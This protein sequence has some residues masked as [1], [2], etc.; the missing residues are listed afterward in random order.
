M[1]SLLDQGQI[2]HD[3]HDPV[4]HALQ[5]KSLGGAFI[6]D[7]FDETDITYV[8]SGNGVGEIQ[9]VTYKLAGVTVHTLTLSYDGS[10]RLITVVKT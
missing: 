6:T 9:T 3:V 2:Y 5:V 1:S 8:P 7:P 4:N 10:N